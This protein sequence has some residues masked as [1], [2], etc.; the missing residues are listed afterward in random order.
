MELKRLHFSSSRRI[1]WGDFFGRNGIL[2]PRTELGHLDPCLPFRTWPRP[3]PGA[4]D[5][6]VCIPSSGDRPGGLS[7]GSD[8]GLGS[9]GHE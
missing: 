3:A 6:V 7:Q 4:S 8:I 9:Q 5:S 2:V 1:P